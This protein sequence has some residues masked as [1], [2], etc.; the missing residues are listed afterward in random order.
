LNGHV[1]LQARC[2]LH[3]RRGTWAVI[4]RFLTQ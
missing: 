4:L 1:I 3:L 2:F